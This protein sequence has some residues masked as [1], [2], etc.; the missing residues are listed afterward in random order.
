MRVLFIHGLG[1][2][3]GGP[4]E[5]AL[6]EAISFTRHD[7]TVIRWGSGKLA[8]GI[9]RTLMHGAAEV[10]A[11][12]NPMR[13]AVRFL[14]H[15]QER[16]GDS[17][18]T[19]LANVHGASLRLVGTIRELERR[20][21]PFSTIGFSLGA[22]VLLMGL[23][24]LGGPPPNMR[25]AVFAGAAV[26]VSAFR[27]IPAAFRT[28]HRLVNVYS[29]SD[30]LLRQVY[31]RMHGLEHAA[32][33]KPLREKGIQNLKVDCGHLSYGGLAA[34][35][36]EIACEPKKRGPVSLGPTKVRGSSRPET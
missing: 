26:S 7:L 30:E 14:V 17:W 5:T 21:E 4:I 15:C 23:Q 16:A 24:H 19:A 22:R 35:L 13:A 32:G 2:Q 9:K 1:G 6:A 11:E 3:G 12:P 29:R 8:T 27:M 20:H 28:G 31:P 33:G 10:L 36:I 34:K 18:D 25:R